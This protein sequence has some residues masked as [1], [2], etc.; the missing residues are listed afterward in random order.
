VL[1]NNAGFGLFGSLEDTSIEEIKSQFETNFF[2]TVRAIQQVIPIMRKQHSGIIVNVSSVGGR[3]GL[4][5]LSSYQASKFA[6]EGLSE[7]IL[8][9]LEPF[10][11]KVVLIEPG[12]IKTNIM[13]SSIPAR[14]ALDPKSPYLTLMQKMES[15]FKNGLENESLP[16][17]EVAKVVLEAVTS[18]NPNLRYTVGSDAANIIEARMKMSDNEFRSMIM[19]NFSIST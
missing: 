16:P 3:M 6:L 4:P 7:S 19:K 1:V 14:K 5:I 10:G 9:E 17:K 2:G 11:I 18:K 13:N 12:I 8:Y 15:Y